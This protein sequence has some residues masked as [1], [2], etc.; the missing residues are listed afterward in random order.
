MGTIEQLFGS[1][2]KIRVLRFF[3]FHPSAAFTPEEL[4][5]R[6]GKHA[7]K[8]KRNLTD[9]VDLEAV[10]IEKSVE[11]GETVYTIN[12][13]WLL[14]HEFRNLFV[15]SQLLV[16]RDLIA[17]LERSGKIRLLILT[18]LFVAEPNSSTDMLIVGS[19]NHKTV[20]RHLTAFEKELDQEVNYTVFT[21]TE[22]NYRKNVGDRFL[23]SIL[24]KPHLVVIDV[25]DRPTPARASKK[26]AV[27]KRTVRRYDKK[28]PT[29]KSSSRSRRRR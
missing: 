12:G 25:T 1:P 8:K 18:G 9:L 5:Q 20:T 29:K 13:D 26:A 23:Y 2:E 4:Q 3:L 22:Y 10:R 15:K 24:E 7:L 11:T 21:N 14:Y 16:E 28:T 27:K 17:R 6:V 19:V